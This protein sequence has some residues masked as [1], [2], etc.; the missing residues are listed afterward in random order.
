MHAFGVNGLVTDI[1]EVFRDELGHSG[2]RLL[3]LHSLVNLAHNEVAVLALQE[4]LHHG[5]L[6]EDVH[7]VKEQGL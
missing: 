1:L 7:E 6:A 2:P 5:V 3:G 4:T